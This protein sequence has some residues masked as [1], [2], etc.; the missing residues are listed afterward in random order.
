MK[1]S[2]RYLKVVEWSDEDQC[3][4]GQC[5]GIIGPCCHG[6]HE[7]QVYSE[8]CKIVDEWIELIKQDGHPLPPPT[9]GRGMVEKI[10]AMA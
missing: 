5:P 4:V 2:A 9:A 3:F 10:S 7:E 6:D 8:L 1:E